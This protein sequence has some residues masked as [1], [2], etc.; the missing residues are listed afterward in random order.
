M[1]TYSIF[2]IKPKVAVH[3]LY[4]TGIIFRFL[5]EFSENP[6]DEHLE[7]QYN[8]VIEPLSLSF[9]EKKVQKIDG[10]ISIEKHKQSMKIDWEG[11]ILKIHKK[12]R[13]LEIHCS[14]VSEMEEFF[15]PALRKCDKFFFV[16]SSQLNDY[17]WLSIKNNR[18]GHKQMLYTYR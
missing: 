5:Q 13:H 9:I 3:Y 14:T 17:G 12:R 2:S 10:N 1:Y 18:A 4:K 11:K 15:F 6:T 16:T 7:L 8:Y